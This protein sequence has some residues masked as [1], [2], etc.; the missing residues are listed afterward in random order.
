ML[1]HENSLGG[2][3]AAYSERS[4]YRRESKQRENTREQQA[5]VDSEGFILIKQ[6]GV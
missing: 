2:T 5:G 4:R 3:R 6:G 1:Q